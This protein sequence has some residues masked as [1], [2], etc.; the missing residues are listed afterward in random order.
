M[1]V[2]LSLAIWLGSF[3]GFLLEDISLH[4]HTLKLATPRSNLTYLNMTATANSEVNS[5]PTAMSDE[6]DG[7]PDLPRVSEVSDD[8]RRTFEGFFHTA[9]GPKDLVI[10][11]KELM[12]LLEHIAPMKILRRY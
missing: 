11:S 1:E 8:A 10:Q 6:T 2:I 12:T 3:L 4:S 5:I 7:G 9:S